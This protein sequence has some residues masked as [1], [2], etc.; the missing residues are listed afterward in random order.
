MDDLQDIGKLE[1]Y[2]EATGVIMIFVSKGYF[3]S[4]NCL[5]EAR[6]TLDKKKPIALMHDPVRGGAP[7]E[8]IKADEC[9]EE[10]LGPVFAGREVI[11]WHRIKDFQIISLKLL[12]HQLLLGCPSDQGSFNH[13]GKDSLGIFLPGEIS[14]TR[15]AFSAPVRLYVS[16][17]NPGAS[18]TAALLSQAMTGLLVTE[19]PPQ[20]LD[21][22]GP[23]ASDTMTK[24]LSGWLGTWRGR[25]GHTPAPQGGGAEVTHMLLYL[26]D[27]TFVGREGVALAVEVRAALARDLPL[28]M[29]HENDVANGG[30]PFARFFETTPKVPAPALSTRHGTLAT[31]AMLCVLCVPYIERCSRRR[32][33]CCA[34]SHRRWAV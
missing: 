31:P 15:L 12:A 17:N 19:A 4:G 14:R 21:P 32:L 25:L 22:D 10:M 26:N 16:A 34:G 7:L 29:L 13:L 2:V 33:T 1:E 30:C 23:V 27:H 9:P 8:A 28:L 20:Q 3:K 5:R 11:E 6:C 18:A 24:S